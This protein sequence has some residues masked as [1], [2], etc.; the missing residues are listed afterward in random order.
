MSPIA[1]AVFERV[2]LN[3]DSTRPKK[4]NSNGI[5]LVLAR[6]KR[7]HLITG[8][9]STRFSR[10]HGRTV[11]PSIRVAESPVTAITVLESW[12]YG[13]PEATAL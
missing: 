1:N 11:G 9:V 2:N 7:T 13:G 4:P 10:A 6:P 12:G 3:P 5:L 8:T